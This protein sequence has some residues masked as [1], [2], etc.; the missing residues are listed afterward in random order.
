MAVADTQ[1]IAADPKTMAA[2]AR[3]AIVNTETAVED[4]KTK[5][6]DTQTKVAEIHR[7]V[8]AGQDS[9]STRYVRL[10]IHQ[11]QNAY[12]PLDPSQ[13]S[14][15]NTMGSP[16][17]HFHSIPLG[18]LPPPAPR[19]CFGRDELIEKM[20]GFAKNLKPVALIGAGEIGKTSVALTVLHHDMIQERFG[21]NRR[22]IRCDQFPASPTHL[23]ARISRVIVTGVENPRT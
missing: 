2:D 13:V 22:F 12:H 1:P 6:T 21:E 23:L 11:H 9:T 3:I 19:D 15:L 17:L 5:V 7:K 16:L 4:T 20:V 8:L 14:E 10:A 18:E